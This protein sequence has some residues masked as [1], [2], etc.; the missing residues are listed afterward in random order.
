M[1]NLITLIPFCIVVPMTIMYFIDRKR[2]F[3]SF[4]KQFSKSNEGLWI[5]IWIKYIFY[6]KSF[7]AQAQTSGKFSRTFPKISWYINIFW[8][9][10]SNIMYDVYISIP[11]NLHHVVFSCLHLSWCVLLILFF[12]WRNCGKI[13]SW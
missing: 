6:L 3:S 11:G 9:R 1:F 5:S 2:Y 12:M 4:L 13:C 7:K 10:I 8:A